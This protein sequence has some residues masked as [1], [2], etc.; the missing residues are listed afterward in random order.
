MLTSF[1]ILLYLYIAWLLNF[2]EHLNKIDTP[3]GSTGK[4]F[5]NYKTLVVKFDVNEMIHIHTHTKT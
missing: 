2:R 1:F 5:T 4:L 3:T